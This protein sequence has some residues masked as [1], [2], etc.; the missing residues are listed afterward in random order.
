[1]ARKNDRKYHLLYLFILLVALIIVFPVLKGSRTQAV[2]L[3]STFSFI[4]TAILYG[5][6]EKRRI[7]YIGMIIGIPWLAT[8]WINLRFD[9]DVLR[10][11]SALLMT[12][13]FSYTLI[14]LVQHI[15]EA[16]EIS[17]DLLSAAGCIYML[18]GFA[19]SG[20]YITMELIKPGSFLQVTADGYRRVDHSHDLVYFSFIT[21]TT[22]GYGDITPQ[23]SLARS[24]AI[25]EAIGGVLF[26]GI[27]IGTLVGVFVAYRSRIRYGK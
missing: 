13:L 20:I 23:T 19:W 6:G 25:L 12:V 9:I 16:K 4:L 8:V 2:M 22:L 7:I 3:N 26:M 5:I 24:F 15:V 21:L 10:I 17:A 11:A 1:M 14:I 18:V 27:L